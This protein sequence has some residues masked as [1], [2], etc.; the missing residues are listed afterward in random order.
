M[1]KLNERITMF[2]K[3]IE[4]YENLF[5]ESNEKRFKNIANNLRA[6]R[7]ELQFLMKFYNLELKAE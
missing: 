6:R 1:K 3:D 2:D 7:G 4:K 5:I